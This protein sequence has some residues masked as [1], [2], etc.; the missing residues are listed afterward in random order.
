MVEQYYSQ[1]LEDKFL[2]ANYFKNKK[3]GIYLEL[4]AL[5]G[6]LYSNTKYFEEHHNWTG[7]LIEP[8]P[9]K[10]E[11]LKKNR[12]NN[13][14]FDNLVSNKTEPLEFLYFTEHL[15]QVSGVVDSL[16]KHHYDVYF[17]NNK[18]SH[19]PQDKILIQ[20]KTLSEIINNTGINHIDLLSLDVEGHEY[21]VLLSFNFDVEIDVILIEMLGVDHDRDNLCRDLL[22]NKG[23]IF[24]EKYEHNE[25]FISSHFKSSMV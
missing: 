17:N 6:L 23:Y 25:I 18:F 9:F 24:C 19:I 7:I 15:T 1:C 16:S 11:L 8:H 21:E 14:N 20:P 4:G 12:P 3:N 22:V 2:N 5:D 13:F 10:F